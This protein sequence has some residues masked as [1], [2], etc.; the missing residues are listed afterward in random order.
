MITF[1][2]GNWGGKYP[3]EYV[4][5][6]ESM[7]A[8]NYTGEF[9]FRVLRDG[10]FDCD[11]REGTWAKMQLFNPDLYHDDPRKLRVWLDLDIV[12]TGSL[13]GR[14]RLW[15][16]ELHVIDDFGSGTAG[17]I[18]SSV[19]WFRPMDVFWIW[20]K[21][22]EMGKPLLGRGDQDIVREL[23]GTKKIRIYDLA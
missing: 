20:Q 8:R 14:F 15:D 12:I 3:E 5:K 13:D 6:L 4:A 21:W 19:M 10:D 7:I 2:C 17:G 1:I 9:A 11:P 23:T 22:C 16:D 18:N